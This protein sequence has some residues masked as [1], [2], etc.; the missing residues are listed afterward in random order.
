MSYNKITIYDNASYGYVV[1]S[2]EILPD[3][4]IE[5]MDQLQETPTWN[6]LGKDAFSI[7]ANF[8]NKLSSS[9]IEGITEKLTGWSIY[10]KE[11]NDSIFEFVSEVEVDVLEFKDPLVGNGKK[12][13]YYVFPNTEN[14]VGVSLTS[15]SITI[16]NQWKYSLIGL[17]EEETNVFVATDFWNFS[18]SIETGT[19]NQNLDIT[20]Y[21]TLQKHNKISKGSHNSLDMS[22][23]CLLGDINSESGEYD[24]SLEKLNAWRKFCVN[25]DKCI[26][27]D[28]SGDIRIVS[29]VGNPSTDIADETSEQ[30]QTV[31]FTVKEVMDKDNIEGIR[32]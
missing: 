21:E 12:Y 27:K 22:I 8:N 25:S 2:R 26:W 11:E 29:I 3:S 30:V 31:G 28:R 9:Y 20:E 1:E 15:E 6:T 19:I 5:I 10:R 14:M 7:L 4:D 23:T 18:L 24:S 16:D 13:I 17:S 32:I